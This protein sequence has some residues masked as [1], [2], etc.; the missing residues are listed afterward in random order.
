[1]IAGKKK[2]DRGGGGKNLRLA[3]ERMCVS[4]LISHAAEPLW[5]LDTSDDRSTT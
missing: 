3:Y 5:T 1:M 2:K 4:T